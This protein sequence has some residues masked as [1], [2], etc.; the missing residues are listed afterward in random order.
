MKPED[1]NEDLFTVPIISAEALVIT[2]RKHY[3]ILSPSKMNAI[4]LSAPAISIPERIL[5]M[6]LTVHRMISGKETDN[7]TEKEAENL[8]AAIDRFFEALTISS[9]Y[10]KAQIASSKYNAINL[11]KEQG[12]IA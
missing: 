6:H 5:P 1:S 4:L 2:L 9:D 11:F 12:W 7:S 3:P 10:S 8:L